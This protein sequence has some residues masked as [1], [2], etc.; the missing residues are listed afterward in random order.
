MGKKLEPVPGFP[1]WLR[2]SDIR[3]VVLEQESR[4]TKTGS[5]TLKQIVLK[6]LGKPA[7]EPEPVHT[8]KGAALSIHYYGD[9]KPRN[10]R[11]DY[12]EEDKAREL[13]KTL[14]RMASEDQA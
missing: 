10:L 4:T 13:A 8:D 9:Y 12:G 1:L 3:E 6:L 11:F 7:P 14:M 5:Y 2:G